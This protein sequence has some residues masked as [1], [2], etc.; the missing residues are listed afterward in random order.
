MEIIGCDTVYLLCLLY[1]SIIRRSCL[2]TTEYIF[3][4]GMLHQYPPPCKNDPTL[5]NRR[6]STPESQPQTKALFLEICVLICTLKC[7]FSPSFTQKNM[8][9]EESMAKYFKS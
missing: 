1:S 4:T 3:S 9:K 7:T 8:R 2:I 5:F 6:E